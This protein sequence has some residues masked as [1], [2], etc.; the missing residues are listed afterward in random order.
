MDELKILAL[1]DY[2]YS[3]SNKNSK[4]FSGIKNLISKND[5][6]ISNLEGPIT[7]KKNSSVIKAGKVLKQSDRSI[8][9]LKKNGVNL[10]SLA[11]NHIF[12]YGDEGVK[13]TIEVCKNEHLKF[14]GINQKEKDAYKINV[15]KINNFKIGIFALTEYSTY[16]N[17]YSFVTPN[18]TD[19]RVEK[20]IKEKAKEL[21]F[22]ILYIHAGVE[23]VPF[24]IKKIRN[25]YRKLIESGADIIFGNHTHVPQGWEKYKN[26][27]IFYSLGNLFFH[28]N[29]NQYSIAVSA[30]FQKSK[31]KS[32][33]WHI[34]KNNNCKIFICDDKKYYNYLIKI[35]KILNDDKLYKKFSNLQ[36]LWIFDKVYNKF[37][38]DYTCSIYKEDNIFIKIKKF[39]KKLFNY[40]SK[41]YN[42]DI[43]ILHLFEEE[44]HRW[45]IEEALRLRISNYDTKEM[46][47]FIDILK[48]GR[49]NE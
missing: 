30:I 28:N 40:K 37:F 41:R 2:F 16:L 34:L 33:N 44:S 1:G 36:S 38:Y 8:Q 39:V 31:I 19:I 7:S 3:E 32:V 47:L 24:P 5:L 17:D 21:D 6:I 29:R 10:V 20:E 11:N 22:I 45:L 26:G 49:I 35:N 4:L 13:N 43:N 27:Y 15:I 14:L 25:R 46:K 9:I 48:E 23:N 18:F 42:K 12:D